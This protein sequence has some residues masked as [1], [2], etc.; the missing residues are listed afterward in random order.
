MSY[1]VPSCSKVPRRLIKHAAPHAVLITVCLSVLLQDKDA[2]V[3]V[4]QQSCPPVTLWSCERC[5]GTWKASRPTDLW[6]TP[7]SLETFQYYNGEYRTAHKYL[8]QQLTNTSPVHLYFS[9]HPFNWQREGIKFTAWRGL[10]SSSHQCRIKC[11][12]GEWHVQ[13]MSR[14]NMTIQIA[15]NW[16][17]FVSRASIT[18][19]KVECADWYYCRLIVQHVRGEWDAKDL[20][21]AHKC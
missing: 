9:G 12:N 4:S 3:F 11:V 1:T 2:I 13:S 7:E 17:T 15:L 10:T 14:R 18:D 6:L 21:K 8:Q 19:L 20:I 5:S 16:M